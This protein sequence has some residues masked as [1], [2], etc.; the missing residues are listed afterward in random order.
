MSQKTFSLAAG[1]VFLVIALMH[2][3]RLALRWDVLVG[4]WAVPMWISGVAIV[5]SGYLASEGLKFGNRN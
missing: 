4:G 1:L 5:I 3:L 2:V